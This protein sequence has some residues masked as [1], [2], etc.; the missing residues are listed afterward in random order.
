LERK[1]PDG[2][3]VAVAR[4]EIVGSFGGEYDETVVHLNL[5]GRKNR[6]YT[7]LVLSH[8]YKDIH[9]SMNWDSPTHLDI[10]YKESERPGDFV[11]THFQAIKCDDV[12]ISA[13]K[14]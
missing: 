9:L 12:T 1:S 5:V 11:Y 2:R 14:T 8:E 6:A 10:K 13:D 4:S 7:I 3:W